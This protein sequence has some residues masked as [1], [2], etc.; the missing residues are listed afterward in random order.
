MVLFYA[1][2]LGLFAQE[3]LDSSLTYSFVQP[4]GPRAING[5]GSFLPWF[6]DMFG[7]LQEFFGN[8]EAQLK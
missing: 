4:W 8:A 2:Q 5:L 1:R 3:S 7:D 6:R